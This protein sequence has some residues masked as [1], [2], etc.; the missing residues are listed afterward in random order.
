MTL[1]GGVLLQLSSLLANYQARNVTTVY[2]NNYPVWQVGQRDRR[3]GFT[4][5]VVWGELCRSRQTLDGQKMQ[6][7][8]D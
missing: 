5:S 1:Q 4:V 2:E 3:M 6:L 8:V 7:S